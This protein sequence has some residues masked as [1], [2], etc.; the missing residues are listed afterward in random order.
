MGK[1]LLVTTTALCV[2]FSSCAKDDKGTTA[3]DGDGFCKQSTI[4]AYNAVVQKAN[5]IRI[6]GA[7]TTDISELNASC[8]SYKSLVGNQ[9]CKA[10]IEGSETT[11]SNTS[12]NT[13]CD[14]AKRA[15]GL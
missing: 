15:M 8:E 9:S 5:L 14:A 1:M 10:S 4:D 13:V 6:S 2:I 7:T 3:V 12:L 11:V